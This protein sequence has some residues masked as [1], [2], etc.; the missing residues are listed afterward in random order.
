MGVELC[1]ACG[2]CCSGA[3]FGH[4]SLTEDDAARLSRRLPVL[5]RR[6]VQP[7]PAHAEDGR[8]TIYEDRPADCER[9]ACGVLERVRAG[10][11]TAGEAATLVARARELAAAVRRAVPGSGPLWP[12]VDR[13]VEDSAEWRRAHRDLLLD[14]A[15][16]RA[17]LDRIEPR[18]S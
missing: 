12:D 1:V 6:L 8:C 10:S 17:L 15:A 4:V 2:L 14:V 11:M 9:Y 13:F 18:R 3:L 16:L 7:C 5:G